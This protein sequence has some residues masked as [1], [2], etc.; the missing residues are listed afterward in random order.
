MAEEKSMTYISAED[1]SVGYHDLPLIEK[2]HFHVDRGEILTLI[3][4]NGAGKSTILK[5]IIGQLKLIKGAVWLD[6]TTMGA[7]KERDIAVRMSVMMTGRVKTERMTCEEVVSMGRYPY[8][9]KMGILTEKDWQGVHD[10]L[11]LVR[12]LDLAGKD[13]EAVSDGQR[14]RVLLARAICQEP[15]V[16]VL[17]EPTAFLDIRHKL[18]LLYLLKN[19]VREK[20]VAVLMSLHE[21]DLAGRISDK[22]ACVR[23]DR[24]DRFGTPEEIFTEGYIPKLYQMTTGSYDELTGDLELPA[25]QGEPKVFVLTGNGT[26]TGVFRRL[27]REGIPF[28][29][30]ILWEN[31][32]DYPSAKALAAEVVSEKVF[33][34]FSE[35]QLARAKQLIDNCERV[36]CTLDTENLGSLGEGLRELK[37][38][39]LKLGKL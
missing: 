6:G 29:A 8:T 23:G 38:Y 14:Q 20:H 32:L 16:I 28:A 15:Q 31:D 24:V 17:D 25:V 27:Q 11:K 39:A 37:E 30:G 19:M 7:M 9:G 1:V 36:I 18:E 34:Q 3:G 22:I 4:P 12:G 21:L 10:S 33:T 5:S 35:A 2:I 26:G 13:F